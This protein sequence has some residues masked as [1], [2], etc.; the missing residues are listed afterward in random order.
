MI[1]VGG[2]LFLTV[3]LYGTRT[4]SNLTRRLDTRL[5]YVSPQLRPLS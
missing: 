3:L 5:H 1:N 2:R 4:L